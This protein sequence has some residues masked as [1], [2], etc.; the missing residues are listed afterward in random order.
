MTP[1]ASRAQGWSSNVEGL[2]ARKVEGR[3][4]RHPDLQASHSG[5]RQAAV[6]DHGVYRPRTPNRLPRL[7]DA[8]DAPSPVQPRLSQNSHG[9]WPGL[10]TL[11]EQVRVEVLPLLSTAST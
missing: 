6:R 11:T 2:V 3:R 7:M 1:R 9:Y 10:T 4:P 8:M 5:I